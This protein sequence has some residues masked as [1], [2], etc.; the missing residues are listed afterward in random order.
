MN[1][2]HFWNISLLSGLAPLANV[3]SW[4]NDLSPSLVLILPASQQI[5]LY[6]EVE[7]IAGELLLQVARVRDVEFHTKLQSQHV[8]S[9]RVCTVYKRETHS[10]QNGHRKICLHAEL[11]VQNH[12]H[13]LNDYT[14]SHKSLPKM[15]AYFF[16]LHVVW[17]QTRTTRRCCMHTYA[18]IIGAWAKCCCVVASFNDSWPSPEV[19]GYNVTGNASLAATALEGCAVCVGGSRRLLS[20]FAVLKCMK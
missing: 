20:F 2:V 1:A 7:E 11:L 19:L 12:K 13:N 5:V 4:W 14:S 3:Y 17:I 6:L 16:Q 15:T 9:Y 18:D 8:R 10:S